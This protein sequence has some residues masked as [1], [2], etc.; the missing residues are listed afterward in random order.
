MKMVIKG[1]NYIFL[2]VI[3]S[4]AKFKRYAH[5]CIVSI[6]DIEIKMHFTRISK[7]GFNSA[8]TCTPCVLSA[9]LCTTAY[10]E[11]KKGRKHIWLN[12]HP[13]FFEKIR[14][15]ERTLGAWKVEDTREGCKEL[16]KVALRLECITKEGK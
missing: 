11:N 2:F 6:F 10:R 12:F 1:Q 8:L 4:L 5:L 14:V 7:C 3:L 9:S 13:N 15:C 16:I